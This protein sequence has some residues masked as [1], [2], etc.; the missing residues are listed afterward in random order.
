MKKNGN[1]FNKSFS[2]RYPDSAGFMKESL[3]TLVNN[4]SDSI[5][6][7]KYKHCNKWKNCKNVKSIKMILK[8]GVNI[9]K[10]VKTVGLL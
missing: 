5:Y 2:I 10:I 8:N 9:K 6:K 3:D 7:L 1:V 4:L